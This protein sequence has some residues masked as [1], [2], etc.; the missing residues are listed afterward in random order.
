MTNKATVLSYNILEG[1]QQSKVQIDVFVEWV[2]NLD[3]DIIFYQE[4]NGFSEESFAK[5]VAR[6]GHPFAVKIK[7]DGYRMGLSSKHEIS[8]IERI[9]QDMRLGYIYAK[10]QD[11]HVFAVHLD[12]FKEEER[13]N[14]IH[15]ILAHAQT[16]PND[17][18]IMIV[19]D[20]NA[21][22][23]SD[24]A[25]YSDPDFIANR[26]LTNPLFTFEFTATNI[27]LEAGY[28]D[29]YALLN[30]D[31]KHSFPTAKRIMP[32][33]QGRRIDYAFLS[34]KLK[35]KCVSA[36]IV[37]DKITRFLSDHYPLVLRFER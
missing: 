8:D 11:Y 33:D 16:V 5:L 35:E 29:A 10:I 27:L 23:E 13:V 2:T 24:I 6:C 7:E 22:A 18:P 28:S 30:S 32:G 37:H 12:P 17:S 4:L 36:E 31:F 20:F 15:K 14:E 34:P 19:G 21:L 1:L 3:P 25:A 26:K 9:T